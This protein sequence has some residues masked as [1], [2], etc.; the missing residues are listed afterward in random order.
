MVLY[1]YSEKYNELEQFYND[2]HQWLNTQYPSPE[3]LPTHL[4]MY[5]SLTP[6][7]NFI[8]ICWNFKFTKLSIQ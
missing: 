8:S 2:P 7:S 3:D 5:N 6:V 1:A 4:I